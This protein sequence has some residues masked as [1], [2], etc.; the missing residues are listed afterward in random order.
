[1]SIKK[2][3]ETLNLKDQIQLY[4]IVFMCYIVVFLFYENIAKM[5]FFDTVKPTQKVFHKPVKNTDERVSNLEVYQHLNEIVKRYNIDLVETEIIQ[6]SMKIEIRGEFDNII[7]FMR[8]YDQ[9]F[10]ID[11]YEMEKIL[12]NTI[13]L[14]MVVDV[15]KLYDN[16]AYMKN[17]TPSIN[18]YIKKVSKSVNE[19]ISSEVKKKSLIR[20]DLNIFINAIIGLEVLIDKEWYT[21]GDIYK[22]YK[23]IEIGTRS[24]VFVNIKTEKEMIVEIIN[25]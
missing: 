18:P 23:I 1:L 15:G 21:I 2:R 13:G 19:L 7:S 12:H 16:K 4:G 24:V 8:E 11:S 3:F 9:K 10:T 5:L 25:E 20:Q 6:N 22:H 14:F 17:K